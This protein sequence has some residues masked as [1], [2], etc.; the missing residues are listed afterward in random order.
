MT[1]QKKPAHNLPLN[2][3]GS[4]ISTLLNN[5]KIFLTKPLNLRHLINPRCRP[6]RITPPRIST[7]VLLPINVGHTRDF[8]GPKRRMPRKNTIFKP[9]PPTSTI[10][11]RLL[12]TNRKTK[13]TIRPPNCE[14][15]LQNLTGN[16][17]TNTPVHTPHTVNPAPWNCCIQPPTVPSTAVVPLTGTSE[18]VG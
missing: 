7:T 18:A 4:R 15:P 14:P 1:S 10:F 12:I 9:R 5:I 11:S 13:I 16:S 3:H 8:K 6:H 2:R 17:S